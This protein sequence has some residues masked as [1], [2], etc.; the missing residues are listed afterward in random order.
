MDLIPLLERRREHI[1]AEATDNLSHTRHSHYAAS[2]E[3]ENKQRLSRLYDLAL[4]CIRSRNL[5]PMIE[6]SE[7]LAEE[8]FKGG[9]DLQEVQTAFNVL[10]EAIW[11]QVTDEMDCDQYPQAFGLTSTTLGTGKE[12]LARQ[13]VSLASKSQ[14]RSL[15]LSQLFRGL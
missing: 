7:K 12:A 9:F 13:Y 15:D 5:V 4:E 10:E 8:R 11:K 3:A 1:L 6:F 2:A 14:V